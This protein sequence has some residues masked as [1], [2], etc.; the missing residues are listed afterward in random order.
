LTAVSVGATVIL[1]TGGLGV[2]VDVAESEA[3]LSGN[4]RGAIRVRLADEGQFVHVNE[5]E[6][7]EVRKPG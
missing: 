4:G 3:A 5:D 1:A 2:V 7:V 6:I